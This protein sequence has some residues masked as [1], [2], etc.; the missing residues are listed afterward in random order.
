MSKDFLLLSIAIP[1]VFGMSSIVFASGRT[2]ARP[3]PEQLAFMDLEVGAFVHFDLNVFTGEEHG[4][5]RAS[6][7]MFNPDKLDAEQWV[8]AAKNLGAKYAVLTARHES[9]FCL[10][11]T[12]TTEYSIA[13]SRYKNGKGDIVREFVEACRK[14]GLKVG[15]YHTAM[16]DAHETMRGYKGEADFAHSWGPAWSASVANAFQS[17]GETFRERFEKVQVEQMTE[18][19]SNYGE[20]SYIWCDHWNGTDRTWR[21]VTEVMRRLQPHC[22]MLG[23][24]TWVPGNEDGR[25]VYPMWNA[26]NTV[27]G[28]IW[29]RP[30]VSGSDGTLANDY[31]LLEGDVLSGTPFGKF[32]RNRECPTHNALYAGG[33]FWHSPGHPREPRMRTL[34]DHV[35]LY[36]RTVGLGANVLINLPPD[37]TGLVPEYLT[38]AAKRLGDEIRSRFASPVASSTGIAPSDIAEVSWGNPTP[39]N[40]VI[41]MENLSHGQKIARYTLEAMVNGRWQPL[42]P[43][44]RF[45]TKDPFNPNPGFETVG[46]KKIDRIEPVTTNR[47]R[48]RCVKSAARP[49]E[50]RSIAVFLCPDLPK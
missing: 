6:P 44:N 39:V 27:D 47:I 26:V 42:V 16:F 31:G 24:D 40:T 5:G 18:L 22:M 30:T 3:T 45:D 13:N 36:Y 1:L 19:L 37:A 20:I 4:N 8:T 49:V 38:T 9:G 34:A 11:S 33:W 32:W 14:H 7:A 15:F 25:V 48:F 17:G 50:L 21:A 28:S 43:A 12:K 46:H 41:L 35:N 23:P 2:L 10:W 29:S